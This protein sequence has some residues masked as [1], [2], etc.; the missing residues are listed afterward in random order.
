MR[1]LNYVQGGPPEW[2]EAE[3]PAME[4]DGEA[5]VRPVAVATC[6]LD[7]WVVRGRVPLAGPLPAGH[8]GVAEVTEVGDAV[9]GVRPG[10][11][12]SVPFQV[13][14]GDCAT[15]RRS[16]TGN[17][18]RVG[19]MATYGIP[20]GENYGGFLSDSVRVPFADAMLVPVPDGVEPAAI[21]SLS[22]NM[23]D[24][25]RAV[26]PQLA[27]KPGAEV[28]ICGGAGSIAVYAAAIALALGAGRVDFAGGE[29]GDRSRAEELGANLLDAEFPERLG[30]YPITVDHSGDRAGLACALRS[31]APEGNCT[32]TAI[33]F[34]PETPVPLLEMY[35]KGI[36]VTTG[37][38][39]ARPAMEPVLELVSDGRLRPERVTAQT[40]DWDDAA[41]ALA[42]HDG[43]LVLTR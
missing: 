13:A 10:D 20:I 34:E 26:G 4:G 2:R 15:C 18:E 14:C 12:V 17:C 39:H 8:E 24:A 37:R 1:E 16:Q 27:A 32:I 30:S 36:H 9:E 43:K 21:A 28:L 38:A 11:L 25:W 40:A 3:A 41:E 19:R 29:P 5:L 35:T 7:L 31:T 42:G 22:D 33:Y 6:D 23:P